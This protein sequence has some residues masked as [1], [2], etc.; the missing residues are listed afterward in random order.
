MLHE[1][2]NAEFGSD[3]N[4]KILT[5][6]ATLQTSLQKAYSR[7]KMNVDALGKDERAPMQEKLDRLFVNILNFNGD[8]YAVEN[9]FDIFL[10][11]LRHMKGLLDQVNDEGPHL[12]VIQTRTILASC[13]DFE[14]DFPELFDALDTTLASFEKEK[15]NQALR[16]KGISFAGYEI[17]QQVAEKLQTLALAINNN[18]GS[19]EKQALVLNIFCDIFSVV[20]A[21]S[22]CKQLSEQFC[23]FCS[24]Q[25]DAFTI[26][27]RTTING[28]FLK[29]IKEKY[30]NLARQL[31]LS[32]NKQS[33]WLTL[34]DS[35]EQ[36]QTI[37]DIFS[38]ASSM[39]KFAKKLEDK[40]L[41][42]F[43]NKTAR[44]HFYDVKK[45]LFQ[46]LASNS[47]NNIGYIKTPDETQEYLSNQIMVQQLNL[48]DNMFAQQSEKSKKQVH[49]NLFKIKRFFNRGY[50]FFS[51]TR[52]Q[53]DAD[54]LESIMSQV[55]SIRAKLAHGEKISVEVLNQFHQLIDKLRTHAVSRAANPRAGKDINMAIKLQTLLEGMNRLGAMDP[56]MSHANNAAFNAILDAQ[57]RF[58]LENRT[59]LYQKSTT[60]FG[61][62]RPHARGLKNTMLDFVFKQNKNQREK[63][64]I[65]L[66]DLLQNCQTPDDYLQYVLAAVSEIDNLNDKKTELTDLLRQQIYRITRD[67][68]IPE[69]NTYQLLTLYRILSNRYAYNHSF[70][71]LIATIKD[72]IKEDNQ[73]NDK[74]IAKLA[75]TQ[76]E[77]KKILDCYTDSQLDLAQDKAFFELLKKGKIAKTLDES[78]QFIV[79]GCVMLTTQESI[80]SALKDELIGLL[81]SQ[82]NQ[83]NETASIEQLIQLLSV[84]KPAYKSSKQLTHQYI[85]IRD[86]VISHSDYNRSSLDGILNDKLNKSNIIV[87]YQYPL[88]DINQKERSTSRFEYKVY[89]M[90]SKKLA[91][92]RI[93]TAGVFKTQE[94]QFFSAASGLPGLLAQGLAFANIP[95]TAAVGTLFTFVLSEYDKGQRQTKYRN[96]SELLES[97]AMICALSKN[98]A[99]NLRKIWEYQVVELGKGSND[100]IDTFA[101]CAVDR[102]LDYLA[103]GEYLRHPE[104]PLE[105]Q[106]TAAVRTQKISHSIMGTRLVGQNGNWLFSGNAY[107]VEDIFDRTPSYNVQKN[108]YLG[109]VGHK[110]NIGAARDGAIITDLTNM[111][112]IDDFNSDAYEQYIYLNQEG[113]IFEMEPLASKQG[114]VEILHQ[115]AERLNHMDVKIERVTAEVEGIQG[116][117]CEQQAQLHHQAFEICALQDKNKALEARLGQ[118]EKQGKNRYSFHAPAAGCG[119]EFVPVEQPHRT[120]NAVAI[121]AF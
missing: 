29:K 83:V 31:R 54:L 1:L 12:E 15:I 93:A 104:L 87:H 28:L 73:V 120:A 118:L 74:V 56:R 19:Y 105:L 14:N 49:S 115:E 90:L 107:V 66:R 32:K 4:T 51:T 9:N 75:L 8:N 38:W 72:K 52:R 53:N 85:Q 100:N 91:A 42:Y 78:I 40:S 81:I 50:S 16:I 17:K 48:I 119:F 99:E 114:V 27:N 39:D 43:K 109:S 21:P 86:Y 116:R 70:R 35:L 20:R 121:P 110:D 101:A 98:I 45:A 3:Y 57:L 26:A 113:P 55:A 88:E 63:S 41:R 117:L 77:T 46:W 65:R 22:V 111:H 112:P 96:I 44:N 13:L 34:M 108:I 67:K 97:D 106:L 71:K 103:K 68:L 76:K 33:Q 7:L 84:M 30:L 82:L 36:V 92:F 11:Y 25:S 94:G 60:F 59:K 37:D 89:S 24:T 23:Y 62:Y 95:N 64:V 18:D 6:I 79:N 80:S 61:A 5:I 10:N 69:A 102:I 47:A 2:L 58:Y